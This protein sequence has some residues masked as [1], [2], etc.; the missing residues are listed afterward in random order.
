MRRR[1]GGTV[2]RI[3]GSWVGGGSG[4][5]L[6]PSRPMDV[7]QWPPHL[8]PPALPHLHHPRPFPASL[9][10]SS[11]SPLPL[12]TLPLFQAHLFHSRIGVATRGPVPALTG[13]TM[14]LK[15]LAAGS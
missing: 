1:G 3:G 13:V 8:L 10:L 4:D 12:S 9:P 6:H 2:A 14:T 7:L 11:T 5:C 15:K